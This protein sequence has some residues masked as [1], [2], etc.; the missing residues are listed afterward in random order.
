[1]HATSSTSGSCCNVSRVNDRGGA[2]RHDRRR[3]DRPRPGGQGLRRAARRTSQP[4]LPAPVAEQRLHGRVEEDPDRSPAHCLVHARSDQREGCPRLD[5]L[6]Q[7]RRRLLSRAGNHDYIPNLDTGYYPTGVKTT[8]AELAT[9]P[10]RR[11][12]WHPEWNYSIEPHP[13]PRQCN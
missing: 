10:L 2:V 12:D 9:V 7:P 13:P 11:H 5:D 1:M 6:H 3:H 8:D 4:R